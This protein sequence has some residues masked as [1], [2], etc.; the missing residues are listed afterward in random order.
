MNAEAK[1]YEG[2]EPYIFISYSHADRECVLAIV[3][4]MD[5]RGYRVWYDAGIHAGEQWTDT[6]ANKIA[7]CKV[8]LLFSS[9]SYIASFAPD[10]ERP[11]C[12]LEFTYAQKTRKPMIPVLLDSAAFPSEMEFLIGNPQQMRPAP[13]ETPEAFAA[14]LDTEPLF[15][16]CRRATTPDAAPPEVVTRNRPVT[17]SAEF[18]GR[19]TIMRDITQALDGDKPVILYGAGG[20]GKS[21]IC[22]KLFQRYAQDAET[23]FIK[24]IGWAMWRGTLKETFYGQFL[25]IEDANIDAHWQKAQAYMQTLGADLLMFLDNADKIPYEDEERL[26]TFGCRFLITSRQTEHSERVRTIQADSLTPEECRTLYRRAYPNNAAPD[27]ALDEIINLAGRHTLA[28]RLLAKTQRAARLS[29]EALLDKLRKSDFDL[30]GKIKYRHTPEDD[31]DNTASEKG[32][33]I[34]HMSRIFVLSRLRDVED[35]EDALRVLQ[36]MSLLAPNT[37]IAFAALDKWLGLDGDF[38]G[39]NCAIDTGWLNETPDGVSIHAVIAAVVRKNAMPDETLIDALAGQ[40]RLD[41][42][43]EETEV[44]TNRLPVVE[45]AIALDN[46]TGA[47]RTEN[48]G[49]MLGQMGYLLYEQADYNNALFY[50]KRGMDI[51]KETLGEEHMEMAT[52]YNNIGEVYRVQGD[53]DSALEYHQKAL[54]IDEKALGTEHPDTAIDYNNIGLVYC[55]L[56]DYDNA[57]EYYQKSLRIRESV[58]GTEHPNTATSYNN[59]GEIY[60]NQ[61]DYD[62]ALEYFQKAL[63]IQEK[64]LGTDHPDTASS[65]HN[66]GMLYF[67]QGDYV[68]ALQWLEK[69]FAVFL[70]V[71]GSKHPYTKNTQR[72]LDDT[73]RK[74]SGEE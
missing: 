10:S 43:P 36:G 5:K 27:D 47:L 51:Q 15:Q 9:A 31:A 41:M 50:M 69:A 54:R 2:K 17:P 30:R 61:G 23:R 71:L 66:I 22:R 59:I 11:F 44:F 21:E 64:T 45:H 68:E 28:V 60:R 40:L 16:R 46:A 58:L 42:I 14:R 19:E 57:L 29:A 6:L 35:G 52:T 56:G 37:P 20:I 55:A 32:A 48:Y 72:W 74:L 1:R 8:F 18:V 12:R 73:K 24:H 26:T 39:L 38:D 13:D 3:A 63:R 70:K 34:D 49:L 33:F 4:A 7:G 65:Y 53:Y 67:E 62:S 25:G